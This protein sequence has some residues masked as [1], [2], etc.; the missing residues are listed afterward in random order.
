MLGIARYELET[1]TRQYGKFGM[2]SIPVPDNSVS[3]VRPPK[4]PQVP[5]YPTEHTLVDIT[6]FPLG[7]IRNV[8]SDDVW[9]S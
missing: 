4:I 7:G 2:T 1:G 3:A 9:W 5:I 6:R 8:K